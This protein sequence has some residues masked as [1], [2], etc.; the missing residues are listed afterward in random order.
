MSNSKNPGVIPVVQILGL[1]LSISVSVFSFKRK[2]TVI[3]TY[4]DCGGD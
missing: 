1:P 3:S 4:R 2:I